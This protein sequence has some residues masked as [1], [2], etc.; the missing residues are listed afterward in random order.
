MCGD[1][2]A[3]WTPAS[4]VGIV[5]QKL[6]SLLAAPSTESPLMP[7][8]AKLYSVRAGAGRGAHLGSPRH[9]DDRAK[10]DELAKACTAKYAM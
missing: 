6:Q 3:G 10:F 7:D 8:I 2:Y 9:Q 5:L 1:V 4:N